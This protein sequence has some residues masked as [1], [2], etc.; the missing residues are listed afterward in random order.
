MKSKSDKEWL[1]LVNPHAGGSKGAHD[2]PKIK[3]LLDNMRFSYLLVTSDFPKHAIKLTIECLKLGFRKII[4]VGGDGTLNEVVNGLFRCKAI[5]PVDVKIGMI[6]VGTGNDW[7]RTFQ[8]PTSYS[9]ALSVIKK[10]ESMLQDV[11]CIQIKS[12]TAYRTRY[13]VNMAG[14][15]FDARVAEKANK[16]KARGKTG[17]FVYLYSLL[18]SYVN[19][20]I[21]RIAFEIDGEGIDDFIFN[22]SIG[23]GKFNG[24][25][26][27]Q[28]PDA[29]PNN[30]V[31]QVTLIKKIGVFGILKNLVGLYN[32]TYINDHRVVTFQAN[33]VAVRSFIP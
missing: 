10:E 8:I 21:R 26:M 27:K 20:R 2:L 9:E 12:K 3:K 7:V 30:G 32:G 25:G 13:F 5:N 23:I 19:Y 16:L 22:A 28:A 4:V 18:S 11:G 24:G 15:G 6:P 31:F 1:V 33:H 17:L 29:I 14:F